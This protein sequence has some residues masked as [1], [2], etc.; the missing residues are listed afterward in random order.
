MILFLN[1]KDLL[2]GRLQMTK[3]ASRFPEYDGAN[4]YNE[5]CAAISSMFVDKVPLRQEGKDQG[6]AKRHVYKHETCATDTMALGAV[7]SSVVDI[8]TRKGIKRL[9]LF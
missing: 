4:E 1:K 2:P 3:F 5:V 6:M 9:N 7:V 8:I